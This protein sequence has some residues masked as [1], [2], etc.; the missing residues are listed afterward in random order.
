MIDIFVEETASTG[1][2]ETKGI[3]KCAAWPNAL[4]ILRLCLH[5]VIASKA[6][7]VVYD[8]RGWACD[9]E[10][11]AAELSV[12]GGNKEWRDSVPGVP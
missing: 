5:P 12:D 11:P 4:N 2:A 1:R 9:C 6:P 7:R 8:G 3:N 10:L